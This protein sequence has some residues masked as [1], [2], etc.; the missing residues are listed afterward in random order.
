MGEELPRTKGLALIERLATAPRVASDYRPFDISPDGA[1]I[2]FTWYRDGNWQLYVTDA[3]GA[4][5]PRRLVQFDDAC[6][7]PQFSRDGRHLYFARDDKG[8]ERFDIYRL[9]LASGALENLLPDSPDFSPEPDFGLSP[10]G[11]QIALAAEHGGGFAA[12]VMPARPEPGA[13]HVRF[14]TAHPYS[15]TSPCWSPDGTRLAFVSATHGQDSAAFVWELESATMRPVGGSTPILAANLAWS[16]DGHSLAFSGGPRDFAA[17]GQYEVA[18]DTVSWLWQGA[19]PAHHPAWSPDSQ[20][21]A[22][23]TDADAETALRLLDLRTGEERCL[24]IG[25]GNHYAP[26]FTP[27]G[28]ALIVVYSGPGAPDDLYRIS[29]DDGAITRLTHSLPEEVRHARFISGRHVRYT[30]LDR[31]TSVPALLCEPERPNG[32]GVVI[33]HGGPTWH[34]SNEWDPLRQ[35]FLA[36][37]CTVVHPNYRGSDGYG[38]RWQLANRYLVGQGEIQDSAGAHALLVSAG[39][40]PARI[41]VTGR[42]WGGFQTMSLLTQF[43]ELWAAG[44]AGVPFF[45]FIEAQED[46]AIR[47]DLRWWDREN[48]GRL[49]TDRA[50]L[51]YYS[52]INHLDRIK[53]PLL[54]LAAENDPRCPP[55]QIGQV[56]ERLRTQGNVCEAV[57]YPAEGH[58][59]SDFG[60]RLDYDRRTVEFLLEHLGL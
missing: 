50:R 33:I 20:R 45:D 2:A 11:T 35:A 38:R 23:L 25:P 53:A 54:L 49:E 16:P 19:Q 29:L 22:F 47:E 9:E 3:Q 34:H 55:S 36:A 14:L 32:A 13:R 52:P 1:Q 7:C 5:L 58:D 59:I 57:I 40:D 8:S 41:G 6:L 15:D 10:D 12:A 4:E 46:P 37:G 48:S 60:H 30:S 31:L 44:V 18:R 39:C 24:S 27:D 28:A 26:R 17:I 21:L 42:S 56:Q 51:E 43:P